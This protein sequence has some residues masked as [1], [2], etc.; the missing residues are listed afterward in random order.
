MDLEQFDERNDDQQARCA[1]QTSDETSNINQNHKTMSDAKKSRLI[2]PPPLPPPPP[3]VLPT[4]L[5]P[6]MPA[7]FN[8]SNMF[9]MPCNYGL[10]TNL[11]GPNF[12]DPPN[13]QPLNLFANGPLNPN[14]AFN[15]MP[16]PTSSLSSSSLPYSIGPTGNVPFIRPL[17]F[18][19]VNSIISPPITIPFLPPFDNYLNHQSLLANRPLL[20][21]THVSQNNHSTASDPKSIQNSLNESCSIKNELAIKKLESKTPKHSTLTSR[22]RNRTDRDRDITIN[23]NRNEDN[24]HR[25]NRQK[26]R[27]NFRDDSKRERK[28]RT[29]I[30]V[31]NQKD[32]NLIV[33]TRSPKMVLEEIF[34]KKVKF[35]RSTPLEPYYRQ[36]PTMIDGKI[37][38]LIEATEKLLELREK[39]KED[40]LDRAEKFRLQKPAFSFPKRKMKFKAHKH[41]HGSEMRILNRLS[42]NL[43]K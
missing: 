7:L 28:N 23:L 32:Q 3:I 38:N 12:L 20:N 17:Q 13:S 27:N 37:I 34:N 25:S 35:L 2:L 31:K 6:A 16:K 9:L 11:T 19:P 8:P 36:C 43:H 1:N 29:Q 40:V 18:N 24:D 41:H 30:N 26:D 4:T 42:F 33:E 22:K 5:T 21:P 15:C 10:R 39:F 14:V